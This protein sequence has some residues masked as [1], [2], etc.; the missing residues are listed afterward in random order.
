MITKQTNNIYDYAP[1]ELEQLLADWGQPAYRARQ[2]YRQLYVALEHD[3]LAMSDLP[4][5]LRQ[6][7]AAETQAGVLELVRLQSADEGMTRKALFRL[8]GGAVVESVLMVY[9]DRA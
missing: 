1:S 8:P 3:P 2:L 5:A 6:R 7:V 4:S 9:P